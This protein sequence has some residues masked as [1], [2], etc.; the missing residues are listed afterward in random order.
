MLPPSSVS[1]NKPSKEPVWNRYQAGFLLG[2]F[3]HSEDG[4]DVF[5]QKR[6]YGLIPQMKNS[7]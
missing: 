3:F 1:K 6:L 4:G 7:S 5:F 2:L